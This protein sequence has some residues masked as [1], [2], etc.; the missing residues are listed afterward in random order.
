VPGSAANREGVCDVELN[1]NR[2]WAPFDELL[3]NLLNSAPL[4][5]SF[6]QPVSR[7]DVRPT[8]VRVRSVLVRNSHLYQFEYRIGKKATHRNLNANDAALEIRRLL[9]TDFRQVTL[10]AAAAE[11][12]VRIDREGRPVIQSRPSDS[13][14]SATTHDRP[15]NH[16][17]PEGEPCAYLVRLGVMDEQGRVRASRYGKFRQINRFLEIAADAVA[18]LT[19]DAPLRVVDFGCGKGYLTFALYDFLSRVRGLPVEMMGMD[20]NR[21][22]MESA[23]GIAR[24]CGFGGL[25]FQAGSIESWDAKPTDMIVSLHA[26]DTATDDVLAKA[27]ESGAAIVLSAPCCQHELS[28]Q[29]S[30]AVMRPV[31][32]H[33][34]LRERLAALVTDAI[35]AQLLEL[36][37]YRVQ[38]LEFIETEHTTKN[39][40][41]RAVRRGTPL[42]V[43]PEEYLRFR[44]FWSVRPYLERAMERIAPD[45]QALLADRRAIDAI[46]EMAGKREP[47]ARFCAE[48]AG[49]GDR[50]AEPEAID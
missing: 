8:A 10:M 45:V 1:E 50:T 41:I 38:V 37:G 18:H 26:C 16:I 5:A 46:V 19:T 36:A 29:I 24:E 49:S 44:D 25:R 40:L 17:L 28:P 47:G 34:I 27:V 2:T 22:L 23:A 3:E 11:Y 14:V 30:S 15:R 43:D 31:L 39:I 13:P 33:G 32:K 9:K 35:R 20:T 4:R 21:Q 42:P 48:S 12:Q 7:G 6:T